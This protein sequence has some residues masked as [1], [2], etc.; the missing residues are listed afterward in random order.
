MGLFGDIVS[1]VANVATG[2]LSG[3][4]AGAGQQADAAGNMANAQ[5]QQAKANQD[6][7]LSYAAPTAAE[8]SQIDSQLKQQTKYQALQDAGLKRDEDLL[9]SLDPALITAG[10]QANDLMNG[11]SAEILAPM[12]QQQTMQRKQLEQKLAAQLGPGFATSS[13][14]QSALQ[15]FDMSSNMQL[16]QAQ[17][18]AFNQVSQF[19]GYNLGQRTAI[20]GEERQGFRTGQEMS[21]STLGEMGD[22]QK[23]QVTATL[24]S[25]PALMQTAG[26]QYA[27]AMAQGQVTSQT[28]HGIAQ[29]GSTIAGA[30]TGS[31]GGAAGGG[32]DA[33]GMSNLSGML[34]S[35]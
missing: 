25:N 33:G 17:M 3:Q 5:M 2:G 11:K 26:G 18:S 14:G 9:G 32:G 27:G 30:M 19:M 23:R 21:S 15:Q 1:T 10:K 34:K 20:V 6:K 29:L 28:A 4:I 12:K 31:M 16:Q 8:L 22:I 35:G 7:A 13:V 24:G